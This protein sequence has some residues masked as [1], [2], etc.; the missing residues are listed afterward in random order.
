MD[1]ARGASRLLPHGHCD[2]QPPDP[3]EDQS[4]LLEPD[5]WRIYLRL[6]ATDDKGEAVHIQIHLK[7]MKS[8]G[9]LPV[10]VTIHY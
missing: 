9:S 7:P 8:T 1:Q 6:G 3:L 5:I 10:N 2:A 4:H